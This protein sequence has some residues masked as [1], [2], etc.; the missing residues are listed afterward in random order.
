MDSRRSFRLFR[1]HKQKAI[2]VTGK[3]PELPSK[4][5]RNVVARGEAGAAWLAQLPTLVGDLEQRWNIAVGRTMP[6]G[7][8]AYVAETVSSLGE[9]GVLKVPIP[10]TDKARR[11]LGVLLAADGRGYARVLQHD[12]ASSAMLLERLG[13]SAIPAG[14]SA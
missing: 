5:L 12:P 3:V 10:G 13:A 8:E 1:G 14:V 7:T 2:I 11:E 9:P 4:V 6:N